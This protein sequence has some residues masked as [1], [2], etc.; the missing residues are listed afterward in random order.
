MGRSPTRDSAI[1][2]TPT[3]RPQDWEP[4]RWKPFDIAV[5]LGFPLGVGIITIVMVLAWRGML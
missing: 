5:A 3:Y 1:S 2:M 4:E